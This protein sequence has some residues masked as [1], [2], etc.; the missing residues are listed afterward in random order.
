MT[1]GAHARPAGPRSALGRVLAAFA[2]A[3]LAAACAASNARGP[4]PGPTPSAARRPYDP[5]A[6]PWLQAA[7]RTIQGALATFAATHDGRFPPV[8]QFP[9]ELVTYLPEADL[10]ASPAWAEGIRQVRNVG[11]AA[12]LAGPAGAPTPIGTVLGA[13]RLPTS[14]EDFTARTW[15]AWCYAHD[16][17]TNR[18]VLYGVGRSG[19][20]AVV[21][22][23]GTPAAE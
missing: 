2:I 19:D 6:E 11:V 1:P 21:G 17:A 3:A 8:A 10:P 9:V 18:Y 16:A 15:G 4:A 7:G 13:G 22:Y 20:L 23:V 12:P 5:A 14:D